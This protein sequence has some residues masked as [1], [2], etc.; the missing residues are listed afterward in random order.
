MTI[1][2]AY[3]LL[4]I[5]YWQNFT[6]GHILVHA[7]CLQEGEEK[8]YIPPHHQNPGDDHQDLQYNT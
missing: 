3:C 6:N 4:L 5:A 2:H 8:G 7:I 1:D